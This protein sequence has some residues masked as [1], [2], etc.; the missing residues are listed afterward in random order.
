MKLV[1]QAIPEGAKDIR[2]RA[3]RD[4]S[5]EKITRKQLNKILEH[6]DALGRIA[7][8]IGTETEK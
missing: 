1:K 7:L 6:L 4:F 3:Y 8:E 5:M 2:K